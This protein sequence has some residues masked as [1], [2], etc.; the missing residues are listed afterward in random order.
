MSYFSKTDDGIQLAE[1]DLKN[2]GPGNLFGT[3]QHGFS[4]L[5]FASWT[6]FQLVATARKVTDDLLAKSQD[7]ISFLPIQ[8]ETTNIMAN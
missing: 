4:N 3:Q 6:N 8:E 2:R 1:Y 5:R 7:W